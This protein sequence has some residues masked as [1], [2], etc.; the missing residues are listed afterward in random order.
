VSASLLLAGAACRGSGNQSVETFASTFVTPGNQTLEH[1]LVIAA[2][3]GQIADSTLQGFH[4]STGVNVTLQPIASGDELLLRLA[5]GDYG[6]VDL[7]LVDAATLSYMVDAEQAE[8]L[9]KKL[10]PNRR[11]LDA[12]FDDSPADPGLRHSIPASYDL[13]GV[14]IST[15]TVLESDT[16][17]SFFSLA[18]RH[19]G[20]VVVPDNADSVIGAALVS[21]GHAWDSDSSSDL[22]EAHD[23]LAE[24]RPSLHV[25]GSRPRRPSGGRQ[26]PALAGLVSG[27]RYRSPQPEVRFFV[28]GEG[29]A[30]DVRSYC[31]PIYAPHPVSAHAWLEH[32][33]DASVEIAAVDQLRTPAPLVVAGAPLTFELAGNEAVAPPAAALAAS[34]QPDISADGREM[35]DQIWTELRL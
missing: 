24:L 7:A 30:I 4:S 12:P 28:P 22:G 29:S 32:W 33:L 26:R 16:W 9:A 6:S 17:S 23:R 8:S 31:I 18:Q 13:V 25:L 11:L 15:K 19:P 27:E 2:P 3:R 20:R 5:A 1:D 21:L 14:A 35:R 34:V 10:L